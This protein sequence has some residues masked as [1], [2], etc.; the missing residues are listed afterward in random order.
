VKTS[1]H[2]HL[3][4]ARVSNLPTT[5]SNVLCALL[6]VG[7]FSWSCF[8]GALLAVSLF[9][10]GGMYLNDW[11]DAAYDRQHRPAR[12]ISAQLITRRAVLLLAATYLLLAF[13]IS[14]ALQPGSLWWSLGLIACITY[15]DLDHKN[16]SMSPWVMGACRALIYPW[17][18]SLAGHSLTSGLWLACLAAY[19]YTM[20]LTYVARGAGQNPFSKLVLLAGLFL[21][22]VLWSTQLSE[23]PLA[24]R[25]L[26]LFVFL[27][28]TGY[29]ISPWFSHKTGSRPP[30]GYLIAGLCWVDL[31]AISVAT[32]ITVAMLLLFAFF[33][34]STL[35]F[36][37][38]ISGT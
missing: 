4:L 13:G 3:R 23:H 26:A 37:K 7:G 22:A 10:V 1:L 20:G 19:S 18:A 36:Q 2:T 15:Y 34:I 32:P 38:T 17:A 14:L 31:L 12:P 27:A 5:W 33:F 9:Y 28:W 29:C 11:R 24:F 25:I 21:P 6:L 30:I 16:N 8:L 35:Q